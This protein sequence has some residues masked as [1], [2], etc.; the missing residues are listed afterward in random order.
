MSDCLSLIST[1]VDKAK[2]AQ[3]VNVSQMTHVLHTEP[4]VIRSAASGYLDIE[5]FCVPELNCERVGIVM[6]HCCDTG[7]IHS[8]TDEVI[9]H[10][11]PAGEKGLDTCVKL[12]CWDLNPK[13]ESTEHIVCWQPDPCKRLEELRCCMMDWM[14]NGKKNSW[15]FRDSSGSNSFMS[16]A[17]LKKLTA[18][19]ESECDA[20]C[21]VNTRCASY[22]WNPSI[23]G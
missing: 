23:C 10:I 2:V 8:W 19:A 13:Q 22:Q 7:K 6:Y 17:L 16:E 14:K 20:A 11:H 3:W 5:S 15:S 9:C 1:R 4:V 21:G 12:D 18:Q